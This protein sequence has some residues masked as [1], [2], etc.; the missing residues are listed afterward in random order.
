MVT[1]PT[2]RGVLLAVIVLVI[3]WLASRRTKPRRGLP[4]V[5]PFNLFDREKWNE[6]TL[7]FHRT[8][9]VAIGLAVLAA[10]VALVFG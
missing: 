1:D 9:A 2:T 7:Q 8:I 10:I 5:T 6:E 4:V 3:G